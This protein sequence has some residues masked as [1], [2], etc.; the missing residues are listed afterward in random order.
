MD[1][2]LQLAPRGGGGTDYRPVCAWIDREGLHPVC[3]L[4]FTD[5]ECTSFPE[6]PEYPVLWII[7]G[8]KDNPPPFGEWIVIN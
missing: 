8:R 2:P 1:L 3:L 5:L 7:D 4:W 6:Q